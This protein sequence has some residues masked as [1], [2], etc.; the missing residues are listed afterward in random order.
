MD[1]KPLE[2]LSILLLGLVLAGVVAFFFKFIFIPLALLI[3][4]YLIATKC[5]R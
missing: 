3:V 2:S 1:S 5:R 4:I